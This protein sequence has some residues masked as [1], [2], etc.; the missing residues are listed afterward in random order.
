MKIGEVRKVKEMFVSPY[1][2]RHDAMTTN[3]GDGFQPGALPSAADKRVCIWHHALSIHFTPR[4]KPLFSKDRRLD[5]SPCWSGQCKENS[6]LLAKIEPGF[7]GYPG[8]SLFTILT[9]ISQMF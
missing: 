6:L 7:R 8:C 9:E 4:K 2:F 1:L 5:T 3:G